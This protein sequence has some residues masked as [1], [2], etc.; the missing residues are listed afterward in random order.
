MDVQSFLVY[1]ALI[2]R[3]TN[4]KIML[5]KCKQKKK[6]VKITFFEFAWSI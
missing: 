4:A 3:K 2:A 5:E 6:I 1:T